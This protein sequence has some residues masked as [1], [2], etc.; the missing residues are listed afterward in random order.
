MVIEQKYLDFIMSDDE[1]KEYLLDRYNTGK[2]RPVTLIKKHLENPDFVA[3]YFSKQE[4]S[5][6]FSDYVTKYLCTFNLK[7]KELLH[8]SSDNLY[9]FDDDFI[10][11]TYTEISEKQSIIYKICSP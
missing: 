9:N 5:N 2:L 10:K 1:S 11:G 3:I 4:Y 8:I 7:N 6:P